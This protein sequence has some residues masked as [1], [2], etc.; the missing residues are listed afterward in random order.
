VGEIRDIQCFSST[1]EESEDQDRDYDGLDEKDDCLDD[2]RKV[3][4]LVDFSAYCVA[5]YSVDH[6]YR[7]V[8][9]H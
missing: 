5:M 2:P 9:V 6:D 7:R 3:L 1:Q 8:Y 4:L